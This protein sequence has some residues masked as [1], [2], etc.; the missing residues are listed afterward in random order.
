MDLVKYYNSLLAWSY[1]HGTVC[2]VLFACICVYE[3]FKS[4]MDV[5]VLSLEILLCSLLEQWYS[6]PICSKS[7]HLQLAGHLAK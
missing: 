3:Y 2:M 6:S 7:F 5:I 4:T 1:L